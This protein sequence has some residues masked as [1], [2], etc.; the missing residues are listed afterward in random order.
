MPQNILV[1]RACP[2]RQASPAR[3]VGRQKLV[4]QSHGDYMVGRARVGAWVL[5]HWSAFGDDGL[6]HM[7]IIVAFHTCYVR[8]WAHCMQRMWLSARWVDGCIQPVRCEHGCTST[9]KCTC[10]PYYLI[11][12]ISLHAPPCPAA[13]LMP[14]SEKGVHGLQN[15][16][17]NSLPMTC[18]LS[19]SHA[20]A[21]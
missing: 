15:L 7:L 11:V 9:A 1:C 17:E 10:W 21:P 14:K 19:V 2:C 5:G 13:S 6:L 16:F 20:V 4:G 8:R 3:N 12:K 18:L